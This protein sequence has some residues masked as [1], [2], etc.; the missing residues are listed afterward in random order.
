MNFMITHI[1]RCWVHVSNLFPWDIN[2]LQSGKRMLNHSKKSTLCKNYRAQCI[3]LI[4]SN[5]CE[6]DNV[7]SNKI[8]VFLIE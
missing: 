6:C 2:Y 8:A 7:R 4:Q 5:V 3:P 1:Y